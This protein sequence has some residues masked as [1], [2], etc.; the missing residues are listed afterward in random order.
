MAVARHDDAGPGLPAGF[1]RV[2]GFARSVSHGTDLDRRA[3]EKCA[4][5]VREVRRDHTHRTEV[6]V[7]AHRERDGDV[8]SRC[9]T[10]RNRDLFVLAGRLRFDGFEG[11]HREEVESA[12]QIRSRELRRAASRPDSRVLIPKVF[13][14]LVLESLDPVV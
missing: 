4:G 13:P 11:G 3:F 6:T 2:G 10:Q 14:S 8:L 12:F 1:V 9:G 5:F 7:W